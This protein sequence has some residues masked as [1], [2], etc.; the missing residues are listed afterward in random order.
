[1]EV[2]TIAGAHAIT[3]GPIGAAGPLMDVGQPTLLADRD[4]RFIK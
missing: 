1:M 4:P 2:G 3:S